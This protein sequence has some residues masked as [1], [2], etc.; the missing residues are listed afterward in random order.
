MAKNKRHE[1]VSTVLIDLGTRVVPMDV[2]RALADY[3]RVAVRKPAGLW[4]M[5]GA[6]LFEVLLN[7][8][9]ERN[10][11]LTPGPLHSQ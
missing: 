11:Q 2:M 1:I 6:G 7:E 9:V 4:I 5:S 10:P 8:R 3:N